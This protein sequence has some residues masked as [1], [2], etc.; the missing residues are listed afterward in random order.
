MKKYF[1][2]S[3]V[4]TAL[5]FSQN[6]Q[7]YGVPLTTQE[8]RTFSV[9]SFS[10]VMR[11]SF[12]VVEFGGSI[13]NSVSAANYGE[14]ALPVV[15]EIVEIPN[16]ATITA[17][18]I[19][20]SYLQKKIERPVFPLQKPVSKSFQ[21]ERKFNYSAQ[22]YRKNNYGSEELVT[23][24]I[25]GNARDKRY[26]K[27]IIHPVK[28]NP[29][30]KTLRVYDKIEYTL[31]IVSPKQSPKQSMQSVAT[32]PSP[33]YLIISDTMFAE[34]LQ[35]FVQ[36]KTMQGY[37]IKT[38]YTTNAEVGKTSTSIK[39]YIKKL[40]DNANELSPAPE[41]LLLVGDV[42]KIPSCSGK[43]NALNGAHS[44]DLY[45]AAI[46]DGDYLPDVAYGRFSASTVADLQVQI[47]KTI[48]MESISASDGSFMDTALIYAGTDNDFGPSHL[49][50]QV[51]YE[52]SQYFNADSGIY[53]TS[54]LHSTGDN[55][56][57]Q[58][59]QAIEKGVSMV[60][61]T[62]HAGIT[63]FSTPIGFNLSAASSLANTGKYP[64]VVGNC[65]LAGSFNSNCFGEALMKNSNGGAVAFIGA[66]SETYFDEDF[67]WS[68]GAVPN[69]SMNQTYTYENTGHSAF[70][71]YF[72][73]HGEPYNEWAHTVYDM[74]FAGNMAVEEGTSENLM[75]QYY[76][77]VYHVLGDPSFM[78]F[79][80][81]PL[82]I[83]ALFD[84]DI[85]V[86]AASTQIQTDPFT[87][88]ALSRNGTLL[89]VVV[90]DQT[91]LLELPLSNLEAGEALLCFT[92]Q[93]YAQRIDTVNFFIPGIAFV[94]MENVVI[95]D[96]NG[97]EKNSFEYGKEYVVSLNMRNKNPQIP[98]N[99]IAL[100]FSSANA[101]VKVVDSVV[102][103][104]TNGDTVAVFNNA[105]KFRVSPDVRNNAVLLL[106][107]TAEVN[108]SVS[109]NQNFS[110]HYLSVAPD[111]I[112]TKTNI[113]IIECG[114]GE[115]AF[116]TIKNT[117]L[118]A[119]ENTKLNVTSSNNYVSFDTSAF[120]IGTLSVGQESGFYVPFRISSS[121]P[122]FSIFD[123]VFNFSSG[124][125]MQQESVFS[126]IST[127]Y[128][129]FE[130]GDFSFID[131]QHNSYP[132][133][134]DSVNFYQGHFSAAS[135][136]ITNGKI[137]TMSFTANVSIDDS[138]S[139]YYKTSSEKVNYSGSVYG[140]YLEFLIDGNIADRWGG[141]EDNWG[142]ASFPVKKGEHVFSWN[143]NKD[144]SDKR[145]EDKVWV[146]NISLPIGTDILF[147]VPFEEIVRADDAANGITQIGS[148]EGSL[149]LR[150]A[151]SQ[152]CSGRLWLSD[153]MG[154]KIALLDGAL[155]LNGGA[156][157]HHYNISGLQHGIYIVV[158]ETPAERITGKI[159]L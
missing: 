49:N 123:F 65:C 28:Y 159:G 103:A 61:Y 83:K 85:P 116:F 34:A 69:I 45:Y 113:P 7:A 141:I 114:E 20:K 98:M 62:G 109:K 72:H 87:R 150:F 6:A 142:R 47:N 26:A 48:A 70:D 27:I 53:T 140:D 74:I 44:T 143:Y 75:P 5:I 21:G 90:A 51:K 78:P 15:S 58:V 105:F 67:Y 23:V 138:I 56:L 84:K 134:I 153:I 36:F 73:T 149:S 59:K 129:T 32:S 13:R 8:S 104:N 120:N 101:D 42:D 14:P 31:Q 158:F 100:K 92:K 115:R 112:I 68:V 131:W 39:N 99:K 132:W 157:F 57:T 54:Y 81:R 139:F 156:E 33:V 95:K 16:G 50:N 66:T 155:R 63:S 1:L 102:T 11:D 52:I 88:V 125:R 121:M 41:Y 91:G 126:H 9:P 37:R 89:G 77:E 46:T 55:K 127:A 17:T 71:R 145:G 110:L 96:E 151:V 22:A 133:K 154:R 108:D 107:L 137:S 80:K 93:F 111:I 64:L 79:R 97:I 35:P 94:G 122:E 40:Y 30:K 146:D 82:E 60:L 136:N 25:L 130:S 43:T 19:K 118:A 135:A 119:A 76:W 2:V 152:K 148:T 18:V 3:A 12:S 128:E 86:L 24:E 10:V 117:G 124:E 147:S 4:F 106:N 38:A 144:F 29:A